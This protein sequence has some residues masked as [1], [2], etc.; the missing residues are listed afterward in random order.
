MRKDRVPVQRRALVQRLKRAL[1]KQSQALKAHAGRPGVGAKHLG[2]YY[3]TSGDAV[4]RRNVDL[5]TL[6]RKLGALQP[7]EE[8]VEDV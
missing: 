6:A 7:Y 4:V 2:R 3:I 8:L 1:A 5:V